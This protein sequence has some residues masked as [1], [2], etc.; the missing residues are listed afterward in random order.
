MSFNFCKTFQL[1]TV[2]MPINDYDLP[3]RVTTAVLDIVLPASLDTIHLYFSECNK[4]LTGILV[5]FTKVYFHSFLSI[6]Q[7]CHLYVSG[8]LPLALQLRVTLSVALMTS[9]LG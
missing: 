8:P 2:L 7:F 4:F 9:L 6:G 3:I 1:Y 5:L